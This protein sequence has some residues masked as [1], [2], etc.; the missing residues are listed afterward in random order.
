MN[1]SRVTLIP[2]LLSL[3]L[4]ACGGPDAEDVVEEMTDIYDEMAEVIEGVTDA[5]S[6]EDAKSEMRDLAERMRELR[7][8]TDEQAV[9]LETIMGSPNDAEL[10]ASIQRFQTAMMAAAEN[11]AVMPHL[12]AILEEMSDVMMDF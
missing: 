11:P 9:E 3:C 10:A 4:S 7:D 2:M 5:E 6:A 1:A 12:D 8:A